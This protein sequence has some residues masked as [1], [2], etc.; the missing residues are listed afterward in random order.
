MVVTGMKLVTLGGGWG[1]GRSLDGRHSN[2]QYVVALG[3][4]RG[5]EESV[6]VA[7]LMKEVEGRSL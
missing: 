4:R 6:M 3:E 5:K 2:V 1:R 7:I